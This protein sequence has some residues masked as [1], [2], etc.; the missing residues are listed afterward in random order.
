MTMTTEAVAAYPTTRVEMTAGELERVEYA[1][2]HPALSE[3]IEG[4]DVGPADLAYPFSIELHQLIP[5]R[6]HACPWVLVLVDWGERVILPFDSQ[7]AAEIEFAAGLAYL[8]E[9][10]RDEYGDG[11]PDDDD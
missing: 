11:A 4:Y 7:R 3:M 6:E 9:E 1:L 8:E 2:R 5:L 10:Y